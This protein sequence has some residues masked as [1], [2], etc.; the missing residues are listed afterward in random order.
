MDEDTG[1]LT[2]AKQ[3]E[4]WQKQFKFTKHVVAGVYTRTVSLVAFHQG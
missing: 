1:T 3:K 4:I 2:L